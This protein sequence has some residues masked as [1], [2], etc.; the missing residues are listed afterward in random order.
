MSEQG[1]NLFFFSFPRVGK[2]A[3]TFPFPLEFR[4]ATPA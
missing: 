1:V 4:M 2:S 3:D